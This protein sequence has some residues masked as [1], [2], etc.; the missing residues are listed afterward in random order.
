MFVLSNKKFLVLIAAM[1]VGSSFVDAAGVRTRHQAKEGEPSE[2]ILKK[3]AKS[4]SSSSSSGSSSGGSNVSIYSNNVGVVTPPVVAPPQP[5]FGEGCSTE[6]AALDSCLSRNAA[7]NLDK[8]GCYG[9]MKGMSLLSSVTDY[10]LKSC[11]KPNF[12]GGFC[13]ECYDDVRNFFNCATGSNLVGSNPSPPPPPPTGGPPATGEGTDSGGGTV[14]NPNAGAGG[15]IMGDYGPPELCPL[16]VP[17]SGDDCSTA[18]YLYLKCTYTEEF[19]TC[20]HDS[21]YFICFDLD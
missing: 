14:A 18:P 8:E 20:R 17:K 19:C 21:P 12:S 4:D 6:K 2:R 11:S 7:T 5:V 1:M 16:E 10:G 15:E 3:N 13:K 9:C